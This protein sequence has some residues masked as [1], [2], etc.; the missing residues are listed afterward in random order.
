MA[1]LKPCFCGENPIGLII[2]E[3]SNCKYSFAFGTCC[4][5]W[6]VQFR[7]TY[8]NDESEIYKLAEQAW[9]EAVRRI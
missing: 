6:A 5:G 8:S 7:T 9:N 4:M 1:K 2:E 3:A